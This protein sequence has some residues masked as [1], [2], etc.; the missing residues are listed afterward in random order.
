[1]PPLNGFVSEW[2]TVQALVHV[3]FGP[4]LGTGLAGGIAAA[5]LAATAALALYCFVKAA[6]LALLGEPR[7]PAAARAV[8]PGPA[9]RL[10][11]VL[12][13]AACVALAAVSGLLLPALAKLAPGSPAVAGHPSLE[14]PGTGSLPSPW[15]LVGI[16]VLTAV[17]WRLRGGRRAA[18]V[19][20]WAC[21]QRIEPSL[22]WTSAGFAKPLVLVAQSVLRPAREV[23]VAR[24]G[25]LVE[26]V[27]YRAEVPH[28]FDVHLYR[29]LRA[30]ALALAAT[31]RRLQS[32]SVRAYAAYLLLMVLALLVLVRVGALG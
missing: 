32:G 8:E 27:E 24:A 1:V 6:G 9:M 26:G 14:L 30:R 15:L 22:R 10:A 4:A 12:L 2:L 25:A 7:T 3:G 5:G 21:G 18:P 16:A 13:A 28:L 11:P 20:A 29:P 23:E 31:M 19:P 17:A